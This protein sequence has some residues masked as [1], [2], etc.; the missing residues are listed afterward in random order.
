MSMVRASRASSLMT[1]VSWEKPTT[2]E[3]KKLM[4]GV[5]AYS[6]G[7]GI[8]ASAGFAANK[9]VLPKILKALSS[10]ERAILAAGFGTAAGLAASEGARRVFGKAERAKGR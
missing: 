3:V 9:F 7:A 1:K 5:A 6:L 4:Q 10:K 8:G 2:K